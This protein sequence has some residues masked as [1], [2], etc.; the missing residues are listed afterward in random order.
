MTYPINVLPRAQKDILDC[1][2]W[3]AQYS[4][5]AAER[6][7]QAFLRAVEQLGHGPMS[8]ALAP[9][10]VRLAAPVRVFVFHDNPR[11][12]YHGVFIVRDGAVHVLRVRGPG[13]GPLTEDELGIE[14][15]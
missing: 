11:R 12:R 6:W 14:L 9:E 5:D 10:A 8:Y 7:Y 3:I 2:Q 4:G 1:Y 13:Q 15:P